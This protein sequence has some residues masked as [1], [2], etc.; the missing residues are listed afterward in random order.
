MSSLLL[1]LFLGH[2]SKLVDLRTLQANFVY[3]V[4]SL[5]DDC[6]HAEVHLTAVIISLTDTSACCHVV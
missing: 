3:V 1:C 6:M 4:G 5:G 2:D